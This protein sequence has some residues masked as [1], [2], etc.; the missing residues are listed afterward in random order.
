MKHLLTTSMA[1]LWGLQFAFLTPA[2]ALLLVDLYDATPA[3]VG[4][5]LAVYNA[6]GLVAALLIPAYADRKNDYLRP[7][8][9]CGILALAL[10]GVLALTTA[11]PAAVT[12]LIAIGGPAGVGMSLLFAHLKHSGAGPAD[13]VNTRAIVSFAWVAGPPLAVFIVDTFGSRA[14]LLALAAVALLNLLA[15]GATAFLQKGTR[16]ERGIPA[17][18][19]AEDGPV[20]PKMAVAGVV[21]GFILLQ[22]TDSAAVTILALFVNERM[23]EG[24]I[25]AGTALGASAALEM[26]ALLIIARLSRRFSGKALIASGCL[27]GLA[28][29]AGMTFVANPITLIGLQ[30]LHAWFFGVVAG[31]GLTL[32]QQIIPRPGLASGLFTNTRRL[33]AIASGPIIAV[34]SMT[35]FGY[36]AVFAACAVLTAVALVIIEVTAKAREQPRS[37]AERRVALRP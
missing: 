1:L 26:P 20:P 31:V 7:M 2:L 30:L 37:Q 32:F 21:I 36:Q 5:V 3:D 15:T 13:V 11:L 6:G 35:A 8:L 17:S 12:A 14:I 27:A 10:P 4:W 34:G 9:L 25:W 16:P 22:A 24:L 23:G 18:P 28:Y 33:G 29:Y 19:T